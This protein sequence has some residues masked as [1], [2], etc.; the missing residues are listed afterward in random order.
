MAAA[1]VDARDAKFKES[2]GHRCALAGL[3]QA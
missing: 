3:L 1:C 2:L